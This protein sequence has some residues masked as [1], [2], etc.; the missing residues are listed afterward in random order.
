MTVSN[1]GSRNP[2]AGTV[3][4]TDTIPTGLTL[5]SMAGDGWACTKNICTRSDALYVT[6]SYPTI[7]V[8]VNVAS[9]AAS[10]VT[11]TVKVTGGSSATATAS[12]VTTIN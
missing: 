5:V 1:N 3:T 6:A 9:N 12:D 7:T 10:S 2:T 8:T 11:N 4:L